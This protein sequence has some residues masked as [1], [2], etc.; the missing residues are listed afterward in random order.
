MPPGHSDIG[1]LVISSKV[2]A[3]N[4][5]R[6]SMPGLTDFAQQAG[7]GLLA[8]RAQR[9][10]ALMAMLDDRD[11]IARDMHD[12]VIQRLFATGLSLQSAAHMASTVSAVATLAPTTGKSEER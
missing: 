6:E 5:P 4:L 12:H 3:E 1:V 9:D 11:R 10:R 8:G 2:A 7:L